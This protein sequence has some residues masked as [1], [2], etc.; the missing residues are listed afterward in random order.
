M[1]HPVSKEMPRTNRKG[2]TIQKQEAKDITRRIKQAKEQLF[3]ITFR[4]SP[5]EMLILYSD[6]QRAQRRPNT[7]RKK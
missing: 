5:N 4:G 7:N 6:G 1:F 3:S 2:N